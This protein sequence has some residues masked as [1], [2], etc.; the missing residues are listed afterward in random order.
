MVVRAVSIERRR[1]SRHAAYLPAELVVEG[2]TPRTAITKDISELGLLLLTRANLDRGQCVVVRIY[3]PGEE[4]RSVDVPGKVVRLEELSDEEKG[5]WRIKVA[6][7]FDKP[8]PEVAQEFKE[9]ATGA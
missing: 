6:F 2:V 1:R 4:L 8:Q 7:T 3:L 5:I 9:L